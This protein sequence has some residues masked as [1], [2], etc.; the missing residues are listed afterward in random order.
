[1][2]QNLNGNVKIKETFFLLENIVFKD[3][4]Y[5]SKFLKISSNNEFL[6]ELA[7]CVTPFNNH[8]NS[9][10]PVFYETLNLCVYKRVD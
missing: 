9:T 2:V 10:T 4:I 1:M 5:C 6:A 8:N 3:K 7:L